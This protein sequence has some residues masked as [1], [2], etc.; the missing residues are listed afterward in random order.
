MSEQM[1]IRAVVKRGKR[2]RKFIIARPP[3]PKVGDAVTLE[4]EEWLVS[5]VQTVSGPMFYI[6]FPARK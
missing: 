6:E 4:N 1:A 2:T 5:K 3:F